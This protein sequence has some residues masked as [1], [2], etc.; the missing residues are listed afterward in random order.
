M[1]QGIFCGRAFAG[2]LWEGFS[3]DASRSDA[4]ILQRP[5]RTASGLT[6]LPQKRP[7]RKRLLCPQAADTGP[8]SRPVPC[9]DVT[10]IRFRDIPRRIVIDRRSHAPRSFR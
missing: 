8:R 3:P 4:L 6:P 5:E 1:W 10:P 2:L 9:R 7:S